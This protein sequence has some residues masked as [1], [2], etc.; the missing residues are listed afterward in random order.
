MNRCIQMKFVG[1]IVFTAILGVVFV[2]GFAAPAFTQDAPEVGPKPPIVV[3]AMDS[4]IGNITGHSAAA[5]SDYRRYCAGCH[6]KE[7]KRKL[8]K[9][10]RGK[11]KKKNKI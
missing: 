2:A 3:K 6:G 10:R 11:R 5:K 9:E 1:A 4:H 7:I 8:I